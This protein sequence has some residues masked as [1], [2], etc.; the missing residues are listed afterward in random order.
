MKRLTNI[1]PMSKVWRYTLA[2]ALLSPFSVVAQ[3]TSDTDDLQEVEGFT[4][5]GSRVKRLDLETVSPVISLDRDSLEQTGFTTVGDALRS[6]S[7]NNGQALTA[8]NSGTSFTPS[9]SSFN[10]RSLGNN[11]SLLLING[12][13]AAPY[14]Q[15]GFDGLQTVFDLNSIP[16]SAIESVEVLKDGAS[17]IY[18]SDAVAGVINVQLRDDYEGMGI[19]LEVGD[20]FS[21]GGL[22]R[23]ISLNFGAISEKTSIFL[24]AFW[25]KQEAVFTRD[26]DWSDDADQTDRASKANP[27]YTIVG[28]DAS[29]VAS[30]EE[31]L[32]GIGFTNP[33]DDGWFDNRSSRGFP[34]RVNIPSSAGVTDSDG[35]VLSGNYTYDNPTDNPTIDGA[36]PGGNPY[37][38]QE[39]AGLFPDSTLLSFYTKAEHQVT[40]WMYVFAEASFSRSEAEVHGAAN[41]IDIE[42]SVGIDP[43]VG[44]IIPSYNPFNPFGIDINTGRR[45]YL[46]SGN[47]INNVTSDTPRFLMGLGGDVMSD[48]LLF[49]DWTWEA[50]MLYSKNTVAQVNRTAADSLLQMALNGLTRLGDGSLE[51]NPDTPQDERVYFNWFAMNEQAFADFTRLINPVSAEFEL[52][53]YDISANGTVGELEGGLIGVAVG[54]EHRKEDWASNRTIANRTGNVLGGSEGTSA[55]GSRDVSA[56]FAEVT[57]PVIDIFELQLAGRYEDYSDE[58]FDSEIRP[59][60]GA[61][62]KP[63]PYLLFR[64][65]YGESFKAPD[66]AYL[67]TA[68]QRTFSSNQVFD[69]VTQ[70]QIDQLQIVVAGNEELEPELTDSY[71]AGVVFEPGEDLFDGKLDGLVLSVEYFQFNQTNLLAQLT[72]VFS[73]QD[74]LQGDFDGDPLFAGKVVRDPSGQVL[75]VRD[76]YANIDTSDYEGWDFAVAYSFRTEASGDFS[77][78][79]N[80]TYLESFKI[81]G[82]EQAGGYLNPEWRF[83]AFANWT[84]GDWGV[85][86]F[87]TYVDER[88]R[89]LAFGNIYTADD[90]LFL[91]YS[92]GSSFR[93]NASVSFSGLYDTQ[94]TVGVNNLF[95]EEPPA[96]PFDGLGATAG[97]TGLAPAY[98]FIRLDREF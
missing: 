50:A 69:P 42:N 91:T 88:T 79:V 63:L 31:Y 10:L 24:S 25:Q 70:T 67:Y 5:T 44:M 41:T 71:F 33:V 35:N 89:S 17:A 1:N 64:A 97:V 56:V 82:S 76:D 29:G 6:L 3:D 43:E 9:V 62:L 26:L 86:L 11:N 23:E 45:R 60:I 14:A 38:Y 27:R 94:I 96:D 98:W 48:N 54:A 93:L 22:S 46:E 55:S 12:R 28:L 75:F 65:S 61:K 85:N 57:L 30:E 77:F 80:G 78:Q 84:Y 21:T 52:Y 73:F 7:F 34:G 72:D 90:S 74:F 66:L 20:Y 36:R 15:P 81:G 32:A 51:W 40:D 8:D 58:G 13:R 39:A 16:A 53:N 18:G 4:V 83:T 2:F 87:G 19:S 68:S 92:P 47:R 49:E 95:D 59:K 37:N